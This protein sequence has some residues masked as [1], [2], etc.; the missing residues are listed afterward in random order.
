MRLAIPAVALAL[1]LA[2]GGATGQLSPDSGPVLATITRMT[3]AVNRGD[4]PTAFAAFT[5]GPTI[6]E[7]LAPYRWSGPGTPQAWVEGMG[8]NAQAHGITVINMKLGPP[9]RIDLTNDHAYAIVPGRLSYT[10]KDGH[11]EHADG[12]IT[13][14]LL[15]AGGDWKIDT[16]VW[17]GPAAKP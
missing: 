7:D 12:L 3:D 10:L 17:S 11:S 6:V 8:A 14:I 16:L 4:M 1:S 13:F 2:A 9:T 5:P 15:R